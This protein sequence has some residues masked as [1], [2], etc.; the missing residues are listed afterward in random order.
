LELFT[1]V[2]FLAGDLKMSD[3]PTA[4]V[5]S[6]DEY[7]A[8]FR[9]GT[10]HLSAMAE[11]E[12]A[13]NPNE[14]NPR[15][16]HNL[17]ARNL[18]KCYVAKFAELSTSILEAVE[19]EQYLTYA[20]CGRSL[21]ENAAT[22]R[23]YA[24][25]KY[26]PLFASGSVDFRRLIEVD[27]Q[28]LRGSKFDWEAFFVGDLRKLWGVAAQKSAA[29]T[30]GAQNKNKARHGLG[31]QPTVIRIGECIRSWAA[32]TPGVGVVYELFCDMVHPNIGSTFLMAS[33]G[34]GGLY[35]SK[36]RGESVGRR[37][38]EKSFPML[39]SVTHEPFGEFLEVL[40]CTIWDEDEI[41]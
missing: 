12:V 40:M 15:R 32:E 22:L 24:K 41:G 14:T 19:K 18:I 7:L 25:H 6:I 28:H 36:G 38:F 10:K 23:Y 27:D 11:M 33:V 34:P 21:I 3:R 9:Q 37:I 31:A 13:W 20:L 26:P 30:K 1:V 5:L 2:E 29:Q 16:L 4:P 39:V 35:F 8:M 17:Y